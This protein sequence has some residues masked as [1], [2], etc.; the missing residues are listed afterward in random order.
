MVRAG[1]GQEQGTS[2]NSV[3]RLHFC[4]MSRTHFSFFNLFPTSKRRC[5]SVQGGKAR[6]RAKVKRGNFPSP[7]F[8]PFLSFFLSFFF[9]F[10]F[11]PLPYTTVG[12]ICRLHLAVNE[13]TCRSGCWGMK[14][15]FAVEIL[16][17]LDGQVGFELRDGE[18]Q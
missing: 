4:E 7:L 3:G 9:F 15:C 5:F 10:F 13:G 17:K 1:A 12:S 16:L 2:T 6:E 14:L 18:L 11:F 8:V